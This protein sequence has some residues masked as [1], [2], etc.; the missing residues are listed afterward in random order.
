MRVRTTSTQRTYRYVRLGLVAASALLAVSLGIELAVGGPLASISAAYYSP[1]GPV[2]VG[3]LFAVA[4]ALLALSGRSVEQ[5]LLDVAAVLALTVA[6]VPTTVD[7]TA[8]GDLARCVPP[9]V[10]PSVVNN[11][12]AVASIVLVGAVVAVILARTQGTASR[13]VALTV[14][15]IVILVLAG[16]V[17]AVIAPVG[18]LALAHT[19]AAVSFFVLV[20]AVAG[21]AAWRPRAGG[22][23][24]RWLRAA[25]AAVAVGIALSL[26]GLLVALIAEGVGVDLGGFPIVF[27]GEAAALTLFLVFWVVQTVELWNEVDPAL[28]AGRE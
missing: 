23:R 8:C 20:G 16:V 14:G 26:G 4:L 22:R 27:V 24:R 17:W 18:F 25:Y 13:G 3:S 2:F 5:G 7:D 10:L 28:M 6:T 19:V 15:A 1:A 9:A 21:L 12:G 11:A